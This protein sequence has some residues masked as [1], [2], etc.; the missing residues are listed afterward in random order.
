MSTEN[1]HDQEAIDKLK[2]LI[3]DIDFCMLQTN[4]GYQPIHSIPMSTKTVRN[5]GTILFLSSS[6]SEHNENIAKSANVQLIYSNK[7]AMEFL[8]IYGEAVILTNQELIEELY[9]STDDTWFDG[10][11]DPSVT[12]IQIKP[13]TAQYWDTKDGAIV[14][15]LKMG[16]GAITGEKV[17]VGVS[18]QLDL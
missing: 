3:M 18:G 8:S 16:Y 1:L 5:D 10:K 4:L 14:S 6:L 9:E 17:D 12:V 2:E 11:E 13:L 15:A 7:N